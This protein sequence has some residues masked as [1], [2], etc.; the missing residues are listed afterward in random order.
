MLA[1][2]TYCESDKASLCWDYDAKVHGANYLVARR[3]R[4]LL[5]HACQSPTPCSTSGSKLGFNVSVCDMC[6]NGDNQVVPWCII[7][8]TLF[9]A[10]IS[11]GGERELLLTLQC[12]LKTKPASVELEKRGEDGVRTNKGR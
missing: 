4:C 12:Y 6:I 2:T 11:S 8:S 1:A 7:S 5:C 9:L 3:V 10:S